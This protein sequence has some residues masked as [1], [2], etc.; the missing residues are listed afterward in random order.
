MA[1]DSPAAFTLAIGLGIGLVVLGV[2]A[3][4]VS[5]FASVTALIPAVFGVVIAALGAVGRQTDRQRQAAYG[6][7]LLAVLGVAGSAR[8]VPDLLALVTGDA[9]DSVVAPVS[10]GLMIL[11]CLVL[12]GAVVQ[13]VRTA[14]SSATP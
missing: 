12:L 11:T 14:R 13:F 8:G 3:Y 5:D 6:I 1:T 10:Q 2:V 9:V 4:V 7:G